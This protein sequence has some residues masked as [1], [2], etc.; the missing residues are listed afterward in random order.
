LI[1][2]PDT[3]LTEL[4][5][6]AEELSALRGN[7]LPTSIHGLSPSSRFQQALDRTRPPVPTH[8]IIGDR[9]RGDGPAGSDGVVPYT[10]SHLASAESE[11]VVPRGHGGIAHPR[12]VAELKRIIRLTLAEI[13]SEGITTTAAAKAPAP[14]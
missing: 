8:S 3:L 9:G 12:A 10:S 7:R 4:G 1:R 14:R 13:P 5:A 2:I 6:G 11:L